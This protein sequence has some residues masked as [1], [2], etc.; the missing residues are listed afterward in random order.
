MLLLSHVSASWDLS[1]WRLCSASATSAGG[2]LDECLW[3]PHRLTSAVLHTSSCMSRWDVRTCDPHHGCSSAATTLSCL[4]CPAVACWDVPVGLFFAVRSLEPVSF[5]RPCITESGAC[6]F[7]Q[8][9]SGAFER[10]ST[11]SPFRKGSA[12]ANRCAQ[13]ELE[14]MEDKR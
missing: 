8:Q 12:L 6:V 3:A 13:S 5:G 4:C 10:N 11:V 14:A 7:T 2:C 1:P 9:T